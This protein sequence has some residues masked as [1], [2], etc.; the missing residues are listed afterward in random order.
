MKTFTSPG[1]TITER[2]PKADFVACSASR[3]YAAD[4]SAPGV[5][6]VRAVWARTLAFTRQY[7]GACSGAAPAM[8]PRN[9]FACPSHLV[10]SLSK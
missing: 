2:N 7:S 5:C 9:S 10:T 6:V 8:K 4:D 1:W 3:L